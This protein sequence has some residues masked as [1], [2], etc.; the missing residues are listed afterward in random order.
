M[1]DKIGGKIMTKLLGLRVKTS[2][3]LRDDGS[4]DKKVERTKKC[5]I[6]RKPKVESYKNCVEAAQ[7]ENKINHQEKN[8]ISIN[9]I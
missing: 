9:S 1:K 2:S 8:K 5:V 3:Y 6:Q 7:L 4:K